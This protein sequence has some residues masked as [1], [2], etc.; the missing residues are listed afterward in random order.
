MK[1]EIPYQIHAGNL[2]K[3][4]HRF[5]YKIEDDFFYRYAKELDFEKATFAVQILCEKESKVVSC[6]Y[7][8][9]GNFVLQCDRSLELFDYPLSFNSS[10]YYK[11]GLKYKEI[12]EDLIVLCEKDP[13]I[14]LSQPIFDLLML[15]IPTRKIHPNHQDEDAAQDDTYFFST[16]ALQEKTMASP[17][18]QEIDPRWKALEKLKN[19]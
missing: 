10:I 16:Q 12:S 13:I 2:R 7:H 11:F 9:T 5:D 14:D 6:D 19:N 17:E 8:F 18:K 4:S 1:A 3:G 15:K